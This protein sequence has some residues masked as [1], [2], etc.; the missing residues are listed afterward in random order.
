MRGIV[1][2][3]VWGSSDLC[4]GTGLLSSRTGLN[5]DFLI[6]SPVLS[7]LG[8]AV[9]DSAPS[10]QIFP[11]SEMIAIICQALTLGPATHIIS[12][13]LIE[14]SFGATIIVV[15]QRRNCGSEELSALQRVTQL[16][17]GI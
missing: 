17:T 7:A 12:W 13:T 9:C 6:L 14:I 3:T 10:L 2:P 8:L 16:V 4:K 5:P 11:P 1:L 15:L